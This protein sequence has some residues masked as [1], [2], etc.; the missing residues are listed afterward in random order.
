M[1]RCGGAETILIS[2]SEGAEDGNG[3]LAVINMV[4]TIMSILIGVVA[5]IGIVYAGIQYLTAGSNEERVVKAKRRIWHIVIGLVAYILMY[6]GAEFLLPGGW[7]NKGSTN[8]DMPAEE[9][10]RGEEVVPVEDKKT[11]SADVKQPEDKTSEVVMPAAA[12]ENLQNVDNRVK[13]RLT[14]RPG[15]EPVEIRVEKGKPINKPVEPSLKGQT[16]NGWRTESGTEY[17]FAKPVNEDMNLYAQWYPTVKYSM[18]KPGKWIFINN[19]EEIHED[20]LANN[21]LLIYKDTVP[22]GQTTEIYYEHTNILGKKFKYALRFWNPGNSPVEIYVNKCG[23]SDAGWDMGMVWHQYYGGTCTMA[24]RALTVQ[25]RSNLTLFH[26]NAEFVA[27]DSVSDSGVYEFEWHKGWDL[28]VLDAVLNITVKGGKLDMAAL[29]YTGDYANTFNAKYEGNYTIGSNGEVYTRVYSGSYGMLPE[30]E[31]NSTFYIN[32]G[33]PAGNMT[34]GWEGRNGVIKH[35]EKLSTNGVGGGVANL[36][37][38]NGCTTT[39]NENVFTS[40]I[41][42]LRMPRISMP[43]GTFNQYY[44]PRNIMVKSENFGY[45]CQLYGWP[46]NWGNWTVKYNDNFTLQ[47]DSTRPRTVAFEMETGENA[48]VGAVYNGDLRVIGPSNK[49]TVWSVTLQPGEKKTLSSIIFLAGNSG[50]AFPRSMIVD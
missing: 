36:D 22:D 41:V 19:P 31:E 1:A 37:M 28:S 44:D 43:I 11:E 10:A 33:T 5:V 48:T 40:D 23:A 9:V 29:A 12:E 35:D 7:L 45:R 15:A 50:G 38:N 42:N 47:N 4:I 32:D 13:V 30:I 18:N 16:F 26:G 8:E 25:P 46:W 24:G 2:C 3:I 39:F 27:S 34:F 20:L 17:D 49:M 6:L 14:T 21:G